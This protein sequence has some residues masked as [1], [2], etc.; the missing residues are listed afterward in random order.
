VAVASQA[1][2]PRFAWTGSGFGVVWADKSSGNQDIYFTKLDSS[3]NMIGNKVALTSGTGDVVDPSILWD[4][5]K[6]YVSYTNYKPSTVGAASDVRIMKIDTAGSV[7]GASVSISN[8]GATATSLRLAKNGT[9]IGAAWIE[10]GG[11][12]NKILSAI[13]TEK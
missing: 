6:F 5:S 1:T 11:A 10:N 13:E 4:G 3:G 8:V 12:T 2:E 7:V 9:T